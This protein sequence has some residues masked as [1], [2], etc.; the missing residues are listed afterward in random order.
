MYKQN[1]VKFKNL[2]TE[3]PIKPKPGDIWWRP[4]TGEFCRYTGSQWLCSLPLKGGDLG[5]I[6]GG[7]DLTLESLYFP[8]DS[9]TSKLHG[10]DL[11]QI[12][13][14]YSAGL[15]SSQSMF[16]CGGGTTSNA[17]QQSGVSR[18]DFN[19]RN[20]VVKLVGALTITRWYP[21][22][23]N[24]SQYGYILC[25]HSF[26]GGNA[27][28]SSI[29]RITFAQD[30]QS[31]VVVGNLT[32][33]TYTNAGINSS[34]YAYSA[35][36]YLSVSTAQHSHLDRMT[37]PFNSGTSSVVGNLSSSV[38]NVASCNS[39]LYG[40]LMGGATNGGNYIKLSI[41]QRFTF[42]NNSGSAVTKGYLSGPRFNNAGLNS[43][44]DGYSC[45]DNAATSAI[46]KIIF[47]FESG[48]SYFVGNLSTSTHNGKRAADNTD[49]ISQF[50]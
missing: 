12:Q 28:R 2:S 49:F 48:V 5:Y 50:V 25:G 4:D 46:D 34:N 41:I 6:S 14:G 27:A 15:N 20:P 45:T 26:S 10:E 39:S 47:P 8:F 13:T 11:F 21:G 29:E 1:V 19:F 30:S 31:S 42:P 24:N 17:A 9:G 38:G 32:K 44:T 37:F 18:I 16:F 35:G 3:Q 22:G 33:S 40:F 43:K 7:S 36:G 23:C